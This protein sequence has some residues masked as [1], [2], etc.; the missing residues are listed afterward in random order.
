[1]NKLT[2]RRILVALTAPLL[3]APLLAACGG[4]SAEDSK[5]ITLSYQIAQATAKNPFDALAEKYEKDHPGVTIKTNP[6][7]MESY[8]STLTTQLQAGNGPDVFF[9]NAGSGQAGS[10]EQL[11]EAGKLLDLSGKVNE[12]IVPEDSKSLFYTNDK[13]YGLPVY[14][15]PSAIIYNSSAAKKIGVELEP[16]G[17]L[18]DLM[19]QC[20]TATDDGKSVL[21]LAGG[22]SANTAMFA[23]QLAASIVYGADPDWNEKRA[24]GEVAFA[25]SPEWQQVLQSIKDMYDADCFQ[26]GA[27]GAGFDALTNGMTQGNMFG[28]MAPAGGAKDIMDST[29]GAVKLEIQPMPAPRGS[30]TYLMAGTPD[31]IAGNA[32]TKNPELVTDFLTWLTEPAQTKEFASASGNIPVGDVT[33][34][35]LLP[36]Y[37]PVADLI[38]SGQTRNYPNLAWANG[39]VYEA[40]GSGI[41]G[42]LTGQKSVDDVL[43]AMDA[44]W[45]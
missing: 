6:I 37:A 34:N 23:N 14:L 15:V 3:T 21:G 27:A 16:T 29:K 42:I 39:E 8:G 38:K 31:G 25:D 30:E 5:T 33:G 26:K 20:R 45:N 12:K 40:Y 18:E 19:G 36:Q 2:S 11:A 4:D 9:I 28:F 10:V 1:M 41:T 7:N 13:L 32:A 44:A 35:D 17:T 43:S 22:T 24:A